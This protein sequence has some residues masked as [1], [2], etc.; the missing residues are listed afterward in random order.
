MSTLAIY[1]TYFF[2]PT[3]NG[4]A[5]KRANFTDN[6]VTEVRIPL[7]HRLQ[8]SQLWREFCVD[9]LLREQKKFSQHMFALM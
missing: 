7:P 5:E 3:A 4:D 2:V 9:L 6:G 8:L 1:P